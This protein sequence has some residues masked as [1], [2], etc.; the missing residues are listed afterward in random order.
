VVPLE[1]QAMQEASAAN[2]SEVTIG[3][4]PESFHVEGD[5]P[6]ISFTAAL[7]EE[8]GADA[9][10][11]AVLKGDDTLTDPKLVVRFDGRVPP[12]INEPLTMHIIT[13][14]AHV[15]H[16]ETGLRLGG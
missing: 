8:L 4:R 1:P 12:S 16:P 7:V 15:F 9:Y 6:A 2:L 3:L 5:G 11:H 10:V 14:E 13:S